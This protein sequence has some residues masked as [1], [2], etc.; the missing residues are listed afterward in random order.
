MSAADDVHI[1]VVD[2]HEA[3]LLVHVTMEGKVRLTSTLSDKQVVLVLRD[4][5]DKYE[6]SHG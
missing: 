5:A 6:A 2:S 1:E 3:A 4:L